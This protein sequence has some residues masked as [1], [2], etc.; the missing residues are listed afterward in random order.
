M[1]FWYARPFALDGLVQASYAETAA[2]HERQRLTAQRLTA[3]VRNCNRDGKASYCSEKVALELDCFY[4]IDET[5]TR[6][7]VNH[8]FN[9]IK[10]RPH[11][12]LL[13]PGPSC[14]VET[15]EHILLRSVGQLDFD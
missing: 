1:Q 5:V 7:F 12:T 3:Q 2:D 4:F 15:S 13:L 10:T 6:G 9:E 14:S 8:F 11:L